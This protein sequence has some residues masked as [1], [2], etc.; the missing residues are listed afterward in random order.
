MSGVDTSIGGSWRLG[1]TSGASFSNVSVN[2]RSSSA[3][4]DSY[5]LGGYTG[6]MVGAF[7]LRGG[8][9]WAWSE[10]DTSRAVIFPGFFERQKAS[11]DAE[12]SQF[13]GEVAYPT[14]MGGMSVEPFAG[15]AYVSIDTDT[16]LERGGALASLRGRDSDQNVGYTTLGVRFAT[17]SQWGSMLVTPHLSARWQHAF[18]DV[19]PTA[20]LAF[21]TTGAGFTVAGVPLAKD[22]AL[23]D[24]G[25]D[26]A[27]AENLD[28][29][30]SYSGQF[31]EGVHDN[32]VKG[33]FTWRF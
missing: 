5:Y 6:G 23:I 22:S 1:L 32:A 14:N 17:T 2:A 29:G 15:L 25:L 33:R 8:G 20:A 12:T 28:A 9:T 11:Y 7:A 16:F 10:I 31:G 30:V 24:A 21:A 27:I 26:F 3:D 13:F 4:A 18:D 19:T